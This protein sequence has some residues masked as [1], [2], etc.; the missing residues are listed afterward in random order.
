VINRIEPITGVNEPFPQCLERLDDAAIE[1][2]TDFAIHEFAHV[3]GGRSVVTEKTPANFLYLGLAEQLFPNATVIWCLRDPLDTCLSCYFH[4]FTGAHPYAY[5]LEH[6]GFCYRMHE[7]LMTH[8][9]AVSSLPIL[10]VQYEELVENPESQM[11]ALLEF[12]D[13][14]WNDA[15]LEFYKNERFVRTASVDQVRQ[16]IYRSSIGRHRRFD[17]YLDP[18]REALGSVASET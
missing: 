12:C 16:P 5:D 8:W 1:R 11:R 18:L 9:C 4:D 15:C 2:L 13:L 14:P 7:R 6:L 10:T 3:A 17:E